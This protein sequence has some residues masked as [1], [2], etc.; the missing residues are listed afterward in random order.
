MPGFSAPWPSPCGTPSR[1]TRGPRSTT[2]PHGPLAMET[3]SG[4]M[5]HTGTLRS[6]HHSMVASRSLVPSLAEQITTPAGMLRGV[7]S[8]VRDDAVGLDPAGPGR[9]HD[10]IGA[11]ERR[12]HHV[13]LPRRRVHHHDA[14]F[15]VHRLRHRA[16]RRPLNEVH[17]LEGI[18]VVPLRRR[19]LRVGIDQGDGAAVAVGG[20][21]RQVD[22]RRRLA[23]PALDVA[24]DDVHGGPVSV[25]RKMRP[26]GT[27]P[28]GRTITAGAGGRGA[29][30]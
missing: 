14:I 11:P 12:L 17:A 24:H 28:S 5:P 22:G 1:S 6:V 19:S 27:G 9:D 21:G 10:G 7:I 15:L 18:D 29:V 3:R 2:L 20:H 8:S 30:W 23:N 26:Y 4:T 13:A 25:A 16:D